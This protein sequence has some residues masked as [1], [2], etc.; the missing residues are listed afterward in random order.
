MLLE[1]P[2]IRLQVQLDHMKPGLPPRRRYEPGILREVTELR[3]T[4]D[5]AVG[6]D[7]GGT[8]HLDVHNRTHP[9]TR[10][11]KGRNAISIMTTGDYVELRRRYGAHLIDGIAG[12]SVLLDFD[13]GL[14]RRVM[15]TGLTIVPGAPR[16]ATPADAG[17]NVIPEG[18]DAATALALVDVHVAKPCVEFTRF[19]LRRTDFDV[20]D[21]VR[22]TLA[23]LDDGARGYKMVATGPGVIRPGDRLIATLPD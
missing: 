11:T 9:R 12:E 2:V 6:I 22:R 20:D 14:A 8:A 1:L 17:D 13:A 5:G 15:P 16:S 10:N 21:D 4:V 3:V 18:D 19:C 7:A 23:D